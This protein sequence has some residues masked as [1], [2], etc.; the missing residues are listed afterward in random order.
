MHKEKQATNIS[1]SVIVTNGSQVKNTHIKTTKKCFFSGFVSGIVASIIANI[2]WKFISKL[3]W[4]F[5]SK[6]V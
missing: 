1:D 4:N 3:V 6:L 5:I 2:I